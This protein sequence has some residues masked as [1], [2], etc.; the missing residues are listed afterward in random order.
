MNIDSATYHF[1]YARYPAVRAA[2]CL[3]AGILAGERG[4]HLSPVLFAVLVLIQVIMELVSYR[5]LSM[6]LAAAV[7]WGYVVLL[8][9][10][11]ALHT[12]FRSELPEVPVALL[13]GLSGATVEVAGVVREARLSDAGTLSAVLQVDSVLVRGHWLNLETRLQVR[14]FRPDTMLA[15]QTR[16]NHYMQAEVTIRDFPQRRNPLAFDVARWLKS[17]G[18]QVVGQLDAV[19][20]STHRTSRLDWLW[21]RA[22]MNALLERSVREDVRPLFKAILLGDK[23]EMDREVR[24]AFSRA[25]LSHLMA[26]S[27]MHVGFVLMPVWLIIPLFWVR[28]SGKALG[29]AIIAIILLFYAGITGFSSSV[30][31]A[32]I[33]A[34]LLAVGKLFQRNR[35]SLNT[36]GVAAIL[37]L[38]WNPDSLFDVGFQMSFVAVILILVL[39]PVLRDGV[40]SAWRFKWSGSFTLFLGI[41]VVVQAGLFPILAGTFGEFSIAGP[42]ANTLGVPVTQALFLWSMLALPVSALWPV[43]A[44]YV[45]VPGEYL[46]RILLWVV[47]VV[48]TQDA[49]WIQITSLS[50]FTGVLWFAGVGC[51]ATLQNPALR[52][53]WLIAVLMVL[54]VMQAGELVEKRRTDLLRVVVYDVG[55]GDAVLLQTPSGKNI[56][57]DTGVLTPFQNSGRSVLVPDLRARGIRKL[58]AVI[59]SHPHA[60]H[61]GGMLSLIEEFPIDV[62]YQS[63]MEFHSAVFTGYMAAASRQGIPVAELRMGDYLDIDPAIR[64]LVLHPDSKPTGSD[65]NAYSV[66]VKVIYGQTSLL[67]TGDAEHHA[68]QA[69]AGR[70]DDFLKSNW[71]KAGHHGSRTSST[72]SFMQRVN[73]D[74]VAVSLGY[75]NRHRHPH[76][77]AARELHRY[78]GHVGF[79]SL[80]GALVYESDGM[81]IRRVLY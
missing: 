26:V 65:P 68:E 63:P 17:D 74:W 60:D 5:N 23:G 18:I 62:I 27:G 10:A 8:V 34:S 54:C 22:A 44:G 38:L 30:S 3:I 64:I 41:S 1:P 15:L 67:L 45:M 51:L 55:Q 46:A 59:L 20:A 11:G 16:Q 72:P 39:G 37:L 56:L 73:P 81:E 19:S 79:T 31:R 52:M 33:T 21:W 2:L 42:L 4:L 57:Y 25:G 43:S 35:D 77:E 66:S 40:P 12:G 14:A 9:L 48:G 24:T 47:E 49:S 32:S 70:F 80:H 50:P 75:R 53:K 61:I 13:K 78:A 76:R 6:T 58:D 69:M 7:R 36:T 29:L 71:Y 28:E